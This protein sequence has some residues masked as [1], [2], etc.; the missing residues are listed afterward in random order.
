MAWNLI[1]RP[2]KIGDLSTLR[3]L[4]TAEGVQRSGW[5]V[6]VVQDAAESDY[7][8]LYVG[9]SKN[10]GIRVSDHKRCIKKPDKASFFYHCARKKKRKVS[11][12]L[13]GFANEDRIDPK[14]LQCWMNIGEQFWSIILQTLQPPQLEEWLKDVTAMGE[15]LGLNIALPINQG[16]EERSR[17]AGNGFPQM[18]RST[19]PELVAFAKAASKKGNVKGHISQSEKEYIGILQAMRNTP[20]SRKDEYWR[21]A[22]PSLN[23]R[24]YLKV[25][26]SSCK[27]PKS[28]RI[29]RQPRYTIVSGKY[30][31]SRKRWCPF[32]I[33]LHHSTFYKPV[34]SHIPRLWASQLGRNPSLL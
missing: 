24:M 3:Q 8:R 18:Y 32:C 21:D 15:V 20:A 7:L 25:I 23:D 34:E 2:G 9:Q 5:Y 27:H 17:H 29:D 30:V 11:F 10:V 13:L 19:D 16:F 22:D 12:F 31:C 28:M 6:A 4:P 33:K 14:F 26:C 1:I